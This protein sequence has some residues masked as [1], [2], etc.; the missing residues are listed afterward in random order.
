MNLPKMVQIT[1]V[2]PRDGF[3]NLKDWIP[4]ENKIAIIEQLAAAGFKRIEL[5]S[6]VHSKAVPQMADAAEILT[7]IKAKYAGQLQCIALVPNLF[8]AKRAI[9]LGA[10]EITFVISASE[11]HNLANTKQTVEQSLAAAPGQADAINATV[12][13]GCEGLAGLPAGAAGA[14][15]GGSIPSG[16]GAGGGGVASPN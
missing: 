4:T 1:E 14:L 12:A 5:T 10:D 7:T 6:F 3:Q 11:A 2:G 8:G 15:V 16:G 9:E 13:L